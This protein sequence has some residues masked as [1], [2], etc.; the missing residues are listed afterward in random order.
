MP[1][2]I[3]MLLAGAPMRCAPPT[4]T[5][6]LAQGLACSRRQAAGERGVIGSAFDGRSCPSGQGSV[7]D[8]HRL[9]TGRQAMS[10]L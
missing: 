7:A 9:P 1:P 5:G 2:P 8:A 6:P 10:G 3:P 4:L